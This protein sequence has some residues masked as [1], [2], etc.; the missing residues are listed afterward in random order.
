M[1]EMCPAWSSAKV[2]VGGLYFEL[3]VCF[4]DLSAKI[5]FGCS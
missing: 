4:L 2:Q 5:I 1:A 3:D